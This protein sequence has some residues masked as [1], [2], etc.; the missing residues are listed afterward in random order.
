[1]RLGPEDG[2]QRNRKQQPRKREQDVDETADRFVHVTAEIPRHRPQAIP[3]GRRDADDD[4]ADQQRDAGAR[5]HS[6]KDVAP[7]LVEAEPVRH[8]WPLQTKR[9]FLRRWIEGRQPRADNGRKDGN[10]DDRGA[11]SGHSEHVMAGTAPSHPRTDSHASRPPRTE[12][13]SHTVFEDRG[14]HRPSR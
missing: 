7:Q 12:R 4:Q 8:R 1:M 13:V 3:I 10:A 5:Q 6:R 9:E 14:R 2:H 11:Y